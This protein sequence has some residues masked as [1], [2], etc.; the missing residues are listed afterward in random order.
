[1]KFCITIDIDWAS[2][3][4]IDSVASQ[5]IKKNL[6]CT[7]FITH[8]SPAVERLK[9]CELFEL[10]IH[11]NFLPNS[12]HG[13]VEDEV[14]KHCLSMVPD[15]KCVRMHALVQSSLLL[16]KLREEY[17]ILIDASLYIPLP[18]LPEPYTI[19]FS[20]NKKGILRIPFV[21]EDDLECY[22]SEKSWDLS[23][24]KYNFGKLNVLN[25]HPMYIYLNADN[26]WGY[27]KIK[28]HLGDSNK[29][30]E[31]DEHAVEAYINTGKGA[32]TFYTGL[33]DYIKNNKHYSC[34]LSQI[35][36]NYSL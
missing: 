8:L 6:R 35:A 14:I 25:F 16:K 21:W 15:A 22:S 36:A 24:S 29:L 32:G 17:G 23:S 28:R 19:C 33:L 20:H 11:P 30:Y 4:M 31:L 18:Q 9:E 3:F 5:L 7:W 13:Q 34:T 10:G 27:E 12:S 1:M 2:D 26:M